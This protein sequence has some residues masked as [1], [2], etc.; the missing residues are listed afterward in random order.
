ME[1]DRKEIQ[2]HKI[3]MIEEIKKLDKKKMFEEK[4]KNKVSIIDKVLKIL[5]Y[6]KKR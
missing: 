1:K 2:S 6:G 4:P 3:Q 5:G